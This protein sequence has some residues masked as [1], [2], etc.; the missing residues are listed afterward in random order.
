MSDSALSLT[1]H[2]I[3]RA[4][5]GTTRGELEE[6]ASRSYDDLVDELLDPASVPDV[7]E[8]VLQRYYPE[9][10][11]KDSLQAWS[12]RWIYRMVN[13]RAPLRDK[14]ALFWHQVFA[15][16][17]HKSEH[18]PC[19]IDQIESFRR[20]GMSDLRTI[21]LELSRD[22]GMVFWLD[23][24]ENFSAEPNENYGRELL[25]IFS[26]GVGNYTE[27]DLKMAARAFTGWTFA[28]P[29]P[30]YPYGHY[31][32]EFKY[33]EEEHDG[34]VKTFLG[35]TGRFD[36]EDILDIIV[37]QP[38]TARFIARH[39][40]NFFV[41]DEAQ[42][43]AWGVE[44]PNDP[45]AI[46]TLAQAYFDSGG[47]I[48]EM[49]RVLFKSDF[50][51]EARFKRV[52]NPAELI[53]GTIKLVGTHRF[54]EPGLTDLV[55][56][57]TVMGQELMNPP[58]VEGWHTGREW[59]NGGTLNARVNFAVDQVG[60]VSKPGIQEIVSRLQDV[61]SPL[62]PDDFVDRCIELAGP[63]EVGDET[64]ASLVRHAAAAGELRF[65]T[66]DERK[67]SAERVARI[68]QLIVAVPEYQM[69]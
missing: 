7:D 34:A 54:P 42:V 58:T 10:T 21:L 37:R 1:A 41:A 17:W 40:Y 45:D 44:P 48:R 62:S 2:L 30:L 36:G 26:M 32:P 35:E 12:G 4:G 33:V 19:M 64:R 49:L 69:A 61:G 16:A 23:N 56:A 20:V 31:E 25:E 68:L 65:D 14:M 18:T 59:V 15:T 43:P 55:Q 67:A 51:K 11:H 24:C 66:E 22:P 3:R 13:S 6:Y 47:D 38:A 50:F 29:I 53:A 57:S 63:L 60:D 46:E 5:F 52:K 27:Q 9:L 8:D 28:Q 39:L